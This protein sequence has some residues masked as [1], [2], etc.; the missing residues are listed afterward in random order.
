M[1]YGLLNVQIRERIARNKIFSFTD[2]LEQ[3][4]H[5]EETFQGLKVKK[6]RET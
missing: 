6:K 1:V 4:R 2:L 3:A 5:V